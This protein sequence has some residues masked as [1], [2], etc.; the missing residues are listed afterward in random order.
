MTEK[1]DKMTE[2][3]LETVKLYKKQNY[4]NYFSDYYQK[5]KE[6]ILKRKK[7]HYKKKGYITQRKNYLAK[8]SP[9]YRT[10]SKHSKI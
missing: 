3:N 8:S 6:K 9:N 5:N 1:Q 10:N 2:S 7:E 4:E